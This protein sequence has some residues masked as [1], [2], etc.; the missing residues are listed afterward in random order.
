M[1]RDTSSKSVKEYRRDIVFYIFF[2]W[3]II[4]MNL[5]LGGAERIVGLDTHVPQ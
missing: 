2:L 5:A 4:K 1:N 3:E